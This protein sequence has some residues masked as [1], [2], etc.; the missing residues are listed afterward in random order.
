MIEDCATYLVADYGHIV[1]GCAS[2][3]DYIITYIL[4][5]LGMGFE[6]CG[7]GCHLEMLL[8]YVYGFQL[9]IGC[10]LYI[11]QQHKRKEKVAEFK[12]EKGQ[13]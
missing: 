7:V 10:Y 13:N 9:C 11:H 6:L 8:I 1:R 5:D 12:N 2:G 3:F 4:S